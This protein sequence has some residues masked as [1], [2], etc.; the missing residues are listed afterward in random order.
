M[1]ITKLLYMSQIFKHILR[2][3]CSMHPSGFVPWDLNQKFIC[4]STIS[5]FS[6]PVVSPLGLTSFKQ[7]MILHGEKC[8]LTTWGCFLIKYFSGK[9]VLDKKMF[10]SFFSI[11]FYIK[12]GP[13]CGFTLPW[14]CFHALKKKLSLNYLRMLTPELKLFW[15]KIL[16][17]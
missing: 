17:K 16:K 4:I 13:L 11:D 8:I 1:F 12:S 3:G 9:L 6:S 7:G 5:S 2:R 14:W 15:R 10:D